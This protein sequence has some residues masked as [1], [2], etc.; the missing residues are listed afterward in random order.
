MEVE[1]E[2]VGSKRKT[3]TPPPVAAPAAIHST[4]DLRRK[5][6]EYLEEHNAMTIASCLRDVPWAA[7]VFY[8]S[9]GFD[10]SF[11][12]NPHSRHGTNMAANKLVSVTIHED[13]RDWRAIR[14]IQLEGRAEQVRSPKRKVRFW[15]IYLKKFPFV[16]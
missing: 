11:L 4:E 8:A 14:G 13:P 10:L 7:A 15:E 2:M 3:P 12:S 5:I 16:E 6:L 9:D 1:K